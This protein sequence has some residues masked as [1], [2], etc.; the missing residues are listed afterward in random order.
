MAERVGSLNGF[1]GGDE[2]SAAQEGGRSLVCWC[3]KFVAIKWKRY[4]AELCR[5]VLWLHA[6]GRGQRRR[7]ESQGPAGWAPTSWILILGAGKQ[8]TLLGQYIY[9]FQILLPA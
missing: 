3:I 7:S 8:L 1:G 6:A 9:R 4:W 2:A 5:G